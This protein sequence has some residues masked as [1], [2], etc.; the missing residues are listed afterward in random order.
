MSKINF[1]GGFSDR[2][3]IMPIN[4]QIQIDA[5]DERT[6]IKLLNL[7]KLQYDDA[8]KSLGPIKFKKEFCYYMVDNIFLMPISS[9]N[10]INESL[11]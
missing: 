4:T 3:N 5:F 6:R 7:L 11:V 2:N 8:C 9:R 10:A 1:R